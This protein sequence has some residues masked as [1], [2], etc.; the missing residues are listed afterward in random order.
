MPRPPVRLMAALAVA[1][2]V[3]A[4]VVAISTAP[5][6]RAADSR[7][8]FVTR[9]G[10]RFCLDGKAFYFAGTNTYDL[11]TYGFDWLP[12]EQYV[13]KAKIDAQMT[14]LQTDGVTVLRLWMFSHEDW[15]GFEA[16]KGVYTEEE[17]ILFDYIMKSARDHFIRLVPVFENYWEAYGGID[18]RLSWEGLPGGEANR[19][20]FFN[21]AQCPGCFTQYKNYVQYALG[22]TNFFTGVKWINDPT[23][24]AWELMNEPRYQNATPNENTTGTTL[25]A[26]VDEMGAF[27]KSLDRNHLLGTGMEGQ[28]TAYGYG[29]DAGNPFVFIQQSP[30]I[31]FTSGHMYPTEGWAGLTFATARTLLKRWIDDSHNLVGKPFFLGEWNAGTDKTTWWQ[32]MYA[33]M[34]ASGGDGDAFWWYPGNTSCGGFD[35]G[36]G[37]PEHAVF[38]QHSAAM[39]AKSGVVVPTS[40]PPTTTTTRP[41]TTTTTRPPT[42]TTSRP[43]TTSTPPTSTPP[44]TTTSRPPTSVPVAGCSATYAITNSWSGGFQAEVTVRNT[45]TSAL[46]G[47]TVGWSLANGQTITQ[48]WNGTLTQSGTTVTVK[49]LTYNGNLAPNTS[50]AFGFLANSTTTNAV[51]ALTCTSP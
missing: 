30:S 28:Q 20:R 25:R 35:S 7:D 6:A 27:V 15:Q 16:A 38:R 45:G 17:F 4:S 49:S 8:S 21:K 19:W 2:A 13:D 14:R 29:G 24:L 33:E 31:D 22:R 32:Q 50:A 26:W 23:V 9:C 43:P 18:K 1:L 42:T 40:R 44:T 37:C 51:P 46:N 48:L 12:G 47:W 36:E 34:E 39:Q 3:L 11:F 41:P 5:P 10:V